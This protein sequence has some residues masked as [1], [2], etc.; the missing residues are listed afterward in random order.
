[1]T[2]V[3]RFN[4]SRVPLA[5]TPLLSTSPADSSIAS[6]VETNQNQESPGM[7]S[8]D[9]DQVQ[10]GRRKKRLNYVLFHKTGQKAEE[11]KK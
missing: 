1:M 9:D 7:P 8:A 2:Q 11:E 5:S 3:D 10:I 4:L 6:P